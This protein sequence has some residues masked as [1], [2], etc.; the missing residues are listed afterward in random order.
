MEELQ[1]TDELGTNI[2][3]WMMPKYSLNSIRNRRA[4]LKALFKKY[5][6]LNQENLRK[7]MKG[8]KHQQYRACLVM[9][10]DYCYE[11]NIPFNLRIPSIKKQPQ[12]LPET[13]S[14]EEIKLMIESA[15]KPYDLTLRCIFNMGAGL[16]V[17]EVIKLSWSHIKWVDWINNKDSY[18][19][20]QIKSGKG[21]KDRV[22]NIPS[23]LMNDLYDYAKQENVLNEFQIPV[24]AM[25][26]PFGSRALPLDVPKENLEK[27]KFDYVE[28]KY[29]WFRY[30]IIQKCCEKAL[31]KHIKVHSLRHSRATYLYEVEGVPV[32][33]IQVLL[34]HNSLNTTML[35]TRVNPRSVFELLKNTTEI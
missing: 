25:I 35:Y 34:G 32:E 1:L 14:S 17:S 23:K 12:K 26:F 8:I 27:W 19:V 4:F 21:S 6:V 5:Q 29:S 33:K 28:D 16:R 15:P 18:G 10:N 20:A 30:N 7:I 3:N 24:G 13:L 22:V 9:I 31:N 11:N 2:I